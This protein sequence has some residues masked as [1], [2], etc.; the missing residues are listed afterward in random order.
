MSHTIQDISTDL[1]TENLDCVMNKNPFIG[2]LYRTLPIS[3]YQLYISN[4]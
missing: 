1:C 2:I 3:C 4:T